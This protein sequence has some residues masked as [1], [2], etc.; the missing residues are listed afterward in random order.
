MSGSKSSKELQSTSR[1]GVS[2]A[3]HI[4]ATTGRCK[5]SKNVKVI[6]RISVIYRQLCIQMVRW[7]NP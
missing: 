2:H 3:R 5:R 1:A 4:R 6:E 7:V